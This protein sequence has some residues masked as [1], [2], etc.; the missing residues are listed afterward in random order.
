[1]IPELPV[2]KGDPP[3]EDIGGLDGHYALCDIAGDPKYPD[4]NKAPTIPLFP[5]FDR[6]RVQNSLESWGMQGVIGEDR[7]PLDNRVRMEMFRS[8][9]SAAE[10]HLVFDTESERICSVSPGGRKPKKRPRSAGMFPP[11]SGSVSQSDIDRDPERYVAVSD[12]PAEFLSDYTD[13]FV[14]KHRR[15]DLCRKPDESAGA[16]YERAFG[17]MGPKIRDKYIAGI[18]NAASEEAYRWAERHGYFFFDPNDSPAGAA[19]AVYCGLRNS[20]IDATDENAV[21]GFSEDYKAE[22]AERKAAESEKKRKNP[23]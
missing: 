4:S 5:E 16:H 22:S 18:P 14:R 15:R 11:P 9:L 20:G 19:E 12:S 1:M 2:W 10:I 13:G 6:D 17:G 7:I 3:P 21:I 8:V 23:S